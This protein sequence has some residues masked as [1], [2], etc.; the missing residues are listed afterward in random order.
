MEETLTIMLVIMKANMISCAAKIVLFVE[1]LSQ[2][3]IETVRGL[4]NT[5]VSRAWCLDI[6]ISKKRKKMP[7]LYQTLTSLLFSFQF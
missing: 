4:K 1:V 5:N 6:T 7:P 3:Y 2:K